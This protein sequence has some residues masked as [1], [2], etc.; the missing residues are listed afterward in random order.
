MLSYNVYAFLPSTPVPQFLSFYILNRMLH[1][2]KAFFTQQVF[3]NADG[4]NSARQALHR[5]FFILAVCVRL[6]YDLAHINRYRNISNITAVAVGDVLTSTIRAQCFWRPVLA[7][8]HGCR[9]V[10]VG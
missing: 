9:E 3:T 6:W 2:V 10:G 4:V 8:L 7:P 1:S 5:E